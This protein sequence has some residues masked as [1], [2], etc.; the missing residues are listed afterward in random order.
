MERLIP[1]ELTHLLVYQATRR[2]PDQVPPWLNEGLATLN[3]FR[4]DPR[5]Q[6]L[7]EQAMAEDRLFPLQQVLCAPFPTDENAARLAYARSESLVRYLQEEYGRPV[8]RE[9]L[10][11][12]VDDPSCEAVVTRVLDKDLKGLDAAW[13][14]YV[15]SQMQISGSRGESPWLALWLLTALLALPLLGVL[16][17]KRK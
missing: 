6:A 12:Y 7:L 5:R 1:H 15:A 13:R 16:R 14:A 17:S 11:A 10:A 3:E 8:I 9:L 4:R 2:I